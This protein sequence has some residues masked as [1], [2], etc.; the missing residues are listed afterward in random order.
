MGIL[1]PTVARIFNGGGTKVLKVLE[2]LAL[3]GIH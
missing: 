2:M 1:L 3:Y